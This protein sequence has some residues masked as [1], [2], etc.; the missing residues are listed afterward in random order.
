MT[1]FFKPITKEKAKAHR[2]WYQDLTEE[3]RR[4]ENRVN[5]FLLFVCFVFM[6]LGF[7][8]LVISIIFLL[9]K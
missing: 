5:W 8:S 3:Q 7:A 9:S 1:N 2:L 6:A 4:H